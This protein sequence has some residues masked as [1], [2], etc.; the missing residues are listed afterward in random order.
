MIQ[1]IREIL[2]H[3]ANQGLKL[4]ALWRALHWQLH[5][6]LTRTPL[7]VPYHGK[8]LRCY[9]ENHSASRAIYFS[10]LPDYSEM[11]FIL[12]Y[13]RPGDTFVDAGANA[14]LYTLL[15]ASV[16]GE[17]GWV[18]AFEPN[19]LMAERLRELAAL[20]AAQNI[21]VHVL[22]LAEYD[23]EISF[24]DTGDDCTAHIPGDSVSQSTTQIP[25]TRLDT[26]LADKDIAMAKFDIEGYEPLA[27]RGAQ[28]LTENANPPVMLIE[29]AGYS[30]RHGISTSDFIQELDEIGYL[31]ATYDPERR[32]LIPTVTPWE[33]PV[34]NVI[35]VAK[36]RLDD[37]A[38]RLR[39]DA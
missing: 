23:G 35:A 8:I 18:H 7:D 24:V 25:V 28:K 33:I 4:R 32:E 19:E 20:N 26:Q 30:Q 3:P 5:K 16:V 22:G 9:P 11:R 37:V 12:D 21:S 15:A 27:I 2:T 13:L 39:R 6:R 17:T 1:L 14:G 31:T 29:M 34:E 36:S 38:G 10:G